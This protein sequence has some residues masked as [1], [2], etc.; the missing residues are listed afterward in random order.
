MKNYLKS[1]RGQFI[2]ISA[3]V[4][5]TIVVFMSAVANIYQVSRAKL[6]V[7]NLADAIALN[8][9]AQEAQHLNTIADRNEWLNHLYANDSGLGTNGLLPGLSHAQDAGVV[10]HTQASAQAYA[11]L[12]ATINQAQALFSMTY[13][14]F[15]GA[16]GSNVTSLWVQLTQDIPD[17]AEDPSIHV[18][19][20]NDARSESSVNAAAE[21]VRRAPNASRSPINTEHMKSL[22][23]TPYDVRVK[24]RPQ[25]NPTQIQT[26]S[27]AAL[28]GI[29]SPIGWMQLKDTG[30][31]TPFM[32][33][34]IPGKGTQRRIGAGALVTKSINVMGAPITVTARSSAY[35]VD[36]SGSLPKTSDGAGGTPKFS[37]TF[38]VK[39]ASK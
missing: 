22:V 27:L 29:T 11:R 34:R 18:I 15:I 33:V 31:A 2:P 26:A 23:F 28:L 7:Q 14:A 3:M 1:R 35:V 5:L 8:L 21:S 38:W 37:P 24:F 20:W 30:G 12:I 19:V 6:Q 36:G 25:S 4:M 32:N 39:L 13:N 16:D 10:F 17:L 9:A